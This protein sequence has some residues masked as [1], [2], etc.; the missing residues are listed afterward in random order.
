MTTNPRRGRSSAAQTTAVDRSNLAS[1][2]EPTPPLDEV[3]RLVNR[4]AIQTFLT[5]FA[6][7]AGLVALPRV[8]EGA[9][10]PGRLLAALPMAAAVGLL[11]WGLR[12][13]AELRRAR[14]RASSQHAGGAKGRSPVLP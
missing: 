12:L 2:A 9:S 8:L 10:G 7:V 6:F 11:A 4:V 14:D 1:P 13:R 5:A 3:T